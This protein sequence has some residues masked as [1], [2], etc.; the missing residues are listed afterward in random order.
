[1]TAVEATTRMDEYPRARLEELFRQQ[2]QGLGT[3]VGQAVA[4]VPHEIHHVAT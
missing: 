1:M 3:G 2:V 4:L